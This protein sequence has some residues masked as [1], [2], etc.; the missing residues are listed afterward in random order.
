[1]N[2]IVQKLKSKLKGTW[3]HRAVLGYKDRLSKAQDHTDGNQL[4][5]ADRDANYNRQTVEV[6]FRVLRRNSNCIDVGAHVGS[7]LQ[8]MIDIS[9]R[10]RHYAF[11]PLPHLSQKLTESF[12]QVIVHQ[13]AVSESSGESEFLF[14][15]NDPGYSGLRRRIYD[16][17]DPKITQIRVRVVTLDEII[18]QNDKIAFIKIDIEGGEFHAMKGGI[19]TIRRCKPVIVFEGSNRSTGQYGVKPDDVYL[20][21]TESL[22]YELSTIERWIK[23]KA[24]YTREE[25]DKNWNRGPEYY[26]IAAPKRETGSR[27]LTAKLIAAIIGLT[28]TAFS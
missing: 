11:E 6:M 27:R 16:R 9:P 17:P 4:P 22:G 15:E 24:A 18:P 7:I 28:R 14:V 19:E 8:Y 25:F 26:F 23:R 21:V 3:I 1:M 13:A 5:P 12:P 10:G 20:L 2:T